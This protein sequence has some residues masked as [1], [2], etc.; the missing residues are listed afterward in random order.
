M[1][2]EEHKK[3]KKKNLQSVGNTNRDKGGPCL[4]AAGLL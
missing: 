4:A 3:Q 1:N 2:G